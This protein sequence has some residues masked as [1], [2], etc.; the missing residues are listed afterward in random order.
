MCDVKATCSCL[1]GQFSIFTAGKHKAPQ[2]YGIYI[3]KDTRCMCMFTYAV[4]TCG[5]WSLPKLI[6]HIAHRLN[7]ALAHPLCNTEMYF[8]IMSV[9]GDRHLVNLIIIYLNWI[10]MW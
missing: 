2:I 4:N 8:I 7:S 1:V 6:H 3:Y 10:K 9:F 5:T